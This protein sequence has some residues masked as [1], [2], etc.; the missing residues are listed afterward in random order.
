MNESPLIACHDCDLLQSLPPLS[1]NESAHCLRCEALLY[2]QKKNSVQRS[3][4][5][6]ITG[7]ILFILAN[8]LPFLTLNAQGQI[9]D[10]T[11]LSASF[12]MLRSDDI[13]LAVLV[14]LT[15]F[16]FPLLDLGGL[17]YV[18]LAIQLDL[19]PWGI[20][21]IFKFIRSA[22]PWGMLEVFMLA[23]LVAAVKLG[24][25][26]SVIPGPALYAF[27]ILIFVM[28]AISAALDPHLIWNTLGA[29]HDKQ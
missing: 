6:V 22:A 27:S 15:T 29:K 12:A 21:P 24:D 28:A 13:G 18:L 26:A 8:A 17:L 16:L 7:I 19:K 3:L 9:Q 20:R 4:A 14:F 25:L 2:K 1:D 5:L 23:V 11:L 10:S